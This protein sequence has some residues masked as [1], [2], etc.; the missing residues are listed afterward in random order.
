MSCTCRF[1]WF[2]CSCVGLQISYLWAYT[3]DERCKGQCYF[4]TVVKLW[5]S[6]WVCTLWPIAYQFSVCLKLSTYADLWM[7][8]FDATIWDLENS[9][10]IQLPVSIWFWHRLLLCGHMSSYWIFLN[11]C[12]SSDL[13]K[14]FS[15]WQLCVSFLSGWY[16]TTAW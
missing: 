8:K 7:V 15:W 4:T 16:T 11:K 3:S 6:H 9:T 2:Q 12:R 13:C 1:L 5:D 14:L 10:V